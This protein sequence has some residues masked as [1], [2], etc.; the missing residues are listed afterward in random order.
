MEIVGA[1]LQPRA[2][3]Q[4]LN[5]FILN[6]ITLLKAN[7]FACFDSLVLKVSFLSFSMLIA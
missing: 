3:P 4:C 1:D 2:L 7:N 6:T 5:N